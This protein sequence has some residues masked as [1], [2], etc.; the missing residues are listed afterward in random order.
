MEGQPIQQPGGFNVDISSVYQIIGALVVENA[1]IK[2]DNARYQ[3]LV[4]Q[5]AT[6]TEAQDEAAAAETPAEGDGAGG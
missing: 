4:Q 5:I 6:P 3:A 1:A 2:L